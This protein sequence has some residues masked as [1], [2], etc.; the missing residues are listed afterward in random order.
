MSPT[1]TTLTGNGTTVSGQSVT[2]TATVTPVSPGAGTPTGNVSF[3]ETPS[4]GLQV[5]INGC[6][7]LPLGPS[8]TAKCTT[9]SLLAQGSSYTIAAQYS[10]DGNFS[11]SPATG[12]AQIVNKASTSTTV[13]S[14]TGSPSV[15]GEPVTYSA[16]VA[17]GS[18]GTGNPTGK[19]EF[20]DTGTPILACGNTSGAS[21]SGT[22]ATC[23]VTTYSSTGSHTITAQYLGDTNY[24]ASAVSSGISQ[25]VS[26]DAT[27]AVLTSTS[28][29]NSATS[30]PGSSVTGQSITYS[31]TVSA[32]LP[33]SGTP[34]GTVTF[35]YTPSGGKAVTMCPTVALVSAK[36]S[37]G[38]GAVLVETGS[39]YTISAS[40]QP[41][42]SPTSF[43][44]SS[45]T[46]TE[47]VS[48]SL[49]KTQLT[50]PSTSNFGSSVSLK[51]T[52]TALA[53]G[54]G[55]PAGT[56]TFYDASAVVG[57]A[58]LASTGI[59]TL[60]VAGLQAGSQSFTANYGG[61]AN[62]ASSSSGTATD[63]VG[64]TQTISGTYS[65]SL[66][67]SSGQLILVTGK[68][69]GS[70][71]VAPGGA[72]EVNGGSI[73]GALA[74]VGAVAFTLCN[75]KV[76]GSMSVSSSTGFVFIGG[77][78]PAGTGCAGSSIGGA[79]ALTNNKGGLEVATSTVSGAAAI[80]GNSGYG[81]VEQNGAFPPPEFAGNTIS[82]ALACS[83]NTPSLTD[84]GMSNKAAIK[85]GQCDAPTTF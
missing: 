34:S 12:V 72:L 37:C 74:S 63:V 26:A 31:A 33:G 69:T 38:D 35:T 77:S 48:A 1:L 32:N 15:S 84:A 28:G 82:G 54:Y 64:F 43:A 62:F 51:A 55:T 68:V 29:A 4:G 57:T 36:A 18:S 67:I 21:L 50:T 40:Y 61:N 75:A 70:V 73:G 76:G 5:P 41:S 78:V 65:G 81:P 60:V 49:T 16:T 27:T 66:V 6:T 46:V 8:A 52:V 17:V 44:A 59:A 22:T 85:S 9:T 11:G 71:A 58:A 47:R 30:T 2:F 79:M 23:T 39:P 56:V 24:S 25:V 20:F 14:T 53:P 7:A 19:V 45:A 80:T 13:V 83:G 42:T 3:L 10:G